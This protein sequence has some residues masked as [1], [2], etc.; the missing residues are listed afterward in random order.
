MVSFNTWRS[1]V[2]GESISAIPDSED[3]HAHY[4]FSANSTTTSFVEDQ[5]GNG[6]DLDNGEGFEDFTTI[7]GRQAGEFDKN[8]NN[9]I[10]S[11]TFNTVSVPYT[12][13]YVV[14]KET[15]NSESEEHRVL[16]VNSSTNAE[17]DHRD[18]GIFVEDG[19][20]NRIFAGDPSHNIVTHR[21]SSNAVLRSQGEQR[22][23]ADQ[24]VSMDIVIV[25]NR[26]GGANTEQG[27][28]GAIGE[29]LIYPEDK[30]NIFEDVEQY[31]AEK[32][33]IDI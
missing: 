22:A 23:T 15:D 7:N 27:F 1:L 32:W 21:R 19:G 25:G 14:D 31:L 9:L 5:S 18:D 28:N 6:H 2:D 12:V 10:Y 20:S 16:G 3:L 11:D 13:F 26:G 29:I 4:D 30:G 24:S 17:I 8:G 33:E